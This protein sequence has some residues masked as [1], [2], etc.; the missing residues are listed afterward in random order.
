MSNVLVGD[1]EKR[2]RL[3]DLR[4]RLSLQLSSGLISRYDEY[5]PVCIETQ[6]CM[7]LCW[8]VL[9]RALWDAFSI[10]HE[11]RDE[12][13]SNAN[14]VDAREWFRISDAKEVF[15]FRWI[16]SQL[17]LESDTINKILGFILE[18]E[19]ICK[20]IKDPEGSESLLCAID[21]STKK[22]HT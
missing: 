5:T 13:L 12:F 3:K 15:S 2:K 9:Y 7:N 18:A 17:Q 14:V 8:A 6:G 20:S 10:P 22:A 21:G 11:G 4:T 19:N 16:A 1:N